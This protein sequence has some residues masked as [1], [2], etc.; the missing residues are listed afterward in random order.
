MQFILKKLMELSLCTLITIIL[1]K[2]MT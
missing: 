2:K 1:D